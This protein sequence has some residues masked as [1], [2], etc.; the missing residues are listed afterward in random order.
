[1][2][3][4]QRQRHQSAQKVAKARWSKSVIPKEV[5]APRRRGRP[6]VVIPDAYLIPKMRKRGLSMRQIADQLGVSE[7]VISRWIKKGV[8]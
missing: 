2:T 1:M 3:G 6:R 4:E 5:S 8:A 7:N